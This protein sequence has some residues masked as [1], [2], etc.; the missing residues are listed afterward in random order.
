MAPSLHDVK[1]VQSMTCKDNN[2][3]D[4]SYTCTGFSS[5]KAAAEECNAVL[6]TTYPNARPSFQS[7]DAK[8]TSSVI[9]QEKDMFL[10]GC[11]N[12]Q[13]PQA[14]VSSDKGSVC[15][16]GEATTSVVYQCTRWP[17]GWTYSQDVLDACNYG[18]D[19]VKGLNPTI[20]AD[21]TYMTM[22]SS[23]LTELLRGTKHISASP[24]A[25]DAAL[26]TLGIATVGE[27]EK[28]IATSFVPLHGT[29]LGWGQ[30]CIA[31]KDRCSSNT[32][33]VAPDT[34]APTKTYCL[35]Y[36]LQTV[37]SSQPCAM[38]AECENGYSSGKLIDNKCIKDKPSD[39][40]GRCGC[41]T[42][43]DC[44]LTTSTPRYCD[45]TSHTCKALPSKWTACDPSS[46]AVPCPYGLECLPTTDT[47]Y[48]HM[49]QEKAG[50]QPMGTDVWDMSTCKIPSWKTNGQLD[51]GKARG[52]CGCFATKGCSSGDYCDADKVCKPRIQIYERC[53]KSALS[54]SCQPGFVC[55]DATIDSPGFPVCMHQAKSQPT[56]AEV[57]DPVSC[58]SQSFLPFKDSQGH[59]LNDLG[60][61]RGTCGCLV[62]PD[63]KPCNHDVVRPVRD[64]EK[65]ADEAMAKQTTPISK[66]AVFRK[67]LAKCEAEQNLEPH[68]NYAA[69]CGE[70]FVTGGRTDTRF[71]GADKL[72]N[73]KMKK[74]YRC[75]GPEGCMSGSECRKTADDWMVCL[76]PKNSQNAGTKVLDASSCKNDAFT[77]YSNHD[78]KQENTTR[79]VCGFTNGHQITSDDASLCSGVDANARP[80]TTGTGHVHTVQKCVNG[81]VQYDYYCANQAKES[82]L[83][84]ECKTKC[85]KMKDTFTLQKADAT[86]KRQCTPWTETTV[87]HKHVCT[88]YKHQTGTRAH[89]HSTPPS[90]ANCTMYANDKTGN[91]CASINE[92]K[93]PSDYSTCQVNKDKTWSENFAYCGV[94]PLLTKTKTW[95]THTPVYETLKYCVLQ[96]YNDTTTGE[97]CKPV[98]H[99][100]DVP[101][102]A[103]CYCDGSTK[104]AC[105]KSGGSNGSE[106]CCKFCTNDEECPGEGLCRNNEVASF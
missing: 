24:V 85:K 16:N 6:N 30:S 28:H 4:V 7:S 69:S 31:D 71:C 64:C 33:C 80:G 54:N 59:D 106:G 98:Y 76:L 13:Y 41:A 36:P 22:S 14:F 75:Q 60:K 88:P 29:A 95:V 65:E 39:P 100:S 101:T 78:T 102:T 25:G 38:D 73:A 77:K 92:W 55:E 48:P 9:I 21:T 5:K 66:G 43:S 63:C 8:S 68:I 47:K 46:K 90:Y 74:W 35:T 17:T 3:Q 27:A 56:D 87:K 1:V 53:V 104:Q 49:C 93:Y 40:L 58:A 89:Y 86:S 42:S 81:S 2:H 57:W 82:T 99:T 96:A 11:Y 10:P 94:T 23:G 26:T 79:G 83:S 67:T 12:R 105:M 52:T 91:P 62:T 70:T 44:A 18:L 15:K 51:P 84:C 72:C 45:P 50:S 37:E 19:K 34:N 20:P 32:V 103:T 97:N 61:P